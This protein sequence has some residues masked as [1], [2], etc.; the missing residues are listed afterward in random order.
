[1]FFCR[2][3]VFSFKLEESALFVVLEVIFQNFNGFVLHDSRNDLNVSAGV[4]EYEM[5]TF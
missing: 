4:Y 3:F 1:M 5:R 2:I